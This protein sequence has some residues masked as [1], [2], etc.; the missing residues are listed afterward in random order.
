MSEKLQKRCLICGRLFET[1]VLA[2]TAL[3]T[4]FSAGG[5]PK[6]SSIC[7]LCEARI[8]KEALDSQDDL[9]PM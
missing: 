6:T 3:E 4:S 5:P 8:K 2:D 7:P 1:D 9:K